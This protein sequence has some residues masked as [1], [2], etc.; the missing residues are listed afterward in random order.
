MFDVVLASK[1]TNLFET[2]SYFLT[3]SSV[4]LHK[5]VLRRGK[6]GEASI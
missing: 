5:F 3:F 4:G 6:K 1:V 2:V